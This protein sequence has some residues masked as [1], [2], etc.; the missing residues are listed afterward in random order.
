MR[1]MIVSFLCFS[2]SETHKF[3]ESNGDLNLEIVLEEQPLVTERR[4]LSIV[5]MVVSLLDLI[6]DSKL[7]GLD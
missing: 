2:M 5:Y 3:W 7:V 4:V 1:N 6:W